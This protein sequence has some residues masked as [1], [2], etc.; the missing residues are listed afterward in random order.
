MKTTKSLLLHLYYISLWAIKDYKG[1]YALAYASKI[2][3]AQSKRSLSHVQGK[4]NRMYVPSA[5]D[6]HK[7][8]V[9]CSLA[10][11]EVTIH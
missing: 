3:N 11:Q 7:V 10:V 5:L 6:D 4:G 1:T 9:L 8:Q 2:S